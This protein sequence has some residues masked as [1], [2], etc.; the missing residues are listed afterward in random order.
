MAASTDMKKLP[1]SKRR[2]FFVARTVGGARFLGIPLILKISPSEPRWDFP[3]FV[4][5]VV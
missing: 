2:I 1:K 4:M 3:K 5:G